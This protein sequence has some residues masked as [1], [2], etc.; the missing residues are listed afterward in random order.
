MT[1]QLKPGD[2]VTLKDY[3]LVGHAQA[4][5][6]RSLKRQRLRPPRIIWTISWK[7]ARRIRPPTMLTSA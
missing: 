1:K 4:D 7:P 2:R 3:G 5:F 6:G